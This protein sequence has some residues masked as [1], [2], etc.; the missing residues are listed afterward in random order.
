MFGYEILGTTRYRPDVAALT[1]RPDQV[2]V[3][4]GADS[5]HLLTHRTTATLAGLLGTTMVEFPGDHG[6]FLPEPFGFAQVLKR[7]LADQPARV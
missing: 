7:V 3:G 5:G 2:V 1:A 6:G 4:V